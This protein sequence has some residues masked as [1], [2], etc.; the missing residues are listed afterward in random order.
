MNHH[1]HHS[2]SEHEGHE[3]W[4]WDKRFAEH[5]WPTEPDPL[6]V[7]LASTIPPCKALDLGC[8]TGRNALWLAKQGF[9]VTGVDASSVGLAEA[10]RQAEAEGVHIELIQADLY[11]YEPLPTSY[12]LVVIANIHPLPEDAHRLYGMARK[13]L[14]DGGHMFIIGHHLEMLG[15][16]GPPDPARLY[17][18]NS[19]RESLPPGLLIE[20]LERVERAH[21]SDIGSQRDV[22]VFVWATAT[23]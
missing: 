23:G 8:G 16:H 17:T 9:E 13:A 3:Q 21:G 14:K 19:L 7:E 22:S 5:G 6:L 11:S 10:A 18:E 4:S 15:H 20:R 1:E 12:G 2:H